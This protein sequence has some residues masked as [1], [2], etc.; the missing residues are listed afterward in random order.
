[1]TCFNSGKESI[2]VPICQGGKQTAVVT[3][4]HHTDQ[5]HTKQTAV[6]TVAHHTDQL[7]TKF[8]HFSVTVNSKYKNNYLGS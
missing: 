8:Y 3:E 7:H 6:V 2:T 1:M 5:L 4:A